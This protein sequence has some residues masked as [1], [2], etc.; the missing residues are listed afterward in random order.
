[1]ELRLTD[2]KPPALHH[3]GYIDYGRPGGSYYYSRTRLGSGH[4]GATADVRGRSAARPGWTTSGATSSLRWRRL[5]LVQ[6]AARRRPELMLYVLR[7]PDGATAAVYGTHVQPDGAVREL[8][9][10]KSV[11]RRWTTGPA[12]TP[13]R[14]TRR[15]GRSLLG[16][17]QRL[18]V[19]PR[20]LDQELYFP[21]GVPSPVV[22]GRR[23]QR[24]RRSHRAGV[25]R[26]DRLCELDGFGRTESR[27]AAREGS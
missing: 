7:G 9:P 26:V 5:G 17:G 13:A 16:D 2:K 1:M 12:R 19:T 8:T 14:G 15:A 22:L 20:I 6:P 24:R 11:S 10:T 25:R 27:P 4:L 3:G 21:D 23:G 18:R